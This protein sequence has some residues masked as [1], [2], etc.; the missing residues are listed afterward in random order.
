MQV[1]KEWRDK[2]IPLLDHPIIQFGSSKQ[3]KSTIR[4]LHYSTSNHISRRFRFKIACN[5]FK[6][7]F[8]NQKLFQQ[9]IQLCDL[10]FKD[11]NSSDNSD[12]DSID[13][14]KYYS[15]K[16]QEEKKTKEEDN[17]QP[18]DNSNIEFTNV[19]SLYLNSSSNISEILRF[20]SKRVIILPKLESI[21]FYAIDNVQLNQYLNDFD[22]YQLQQLIKLKTLV[23]INVNN[24]D[25]EILNYQFIHLKSLVFHNTN[26]DFNSISQYLKSTKTLENF[27]Y[28]NYNSSG[29]NELL[30]NSLAH[31]NSIQNLVLIS[32]MSVVLM[33]SIIEFLSVN[34]TVTDLKLEVDTRITG[35]EMRFMNTN[36]LSLTSNNSTE[37]LGYWDWNSTLIGINSPISL[38]PRLV[39]KL[40]S[41]HYQI[42]YLSI[43]PMTNQIIPH[44]LL[45]QLIAIEINSYAFENY[46]E[47]KQDRNT[48]RMW[49]EFFN[50]LKSVQL[51]REIKF[52]KLL[53]TDL[54]LDFFN[55]Q[56]PTI[57]VVSLDFYITEPLTSFEALQFKHFGNIISSNRTLKSLSLSFQE[58]SMEYGVVL[59]DLLISIIQSQNNIEYL[60]FRQSFSD[61]SLSHTKVLQ[62]CNAIT[63]NLKLQYYC[64][65]KY[66]DSYPLIEQTL[67][68]NFKTTN[69]SNS[70]FSF[71]K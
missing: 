69:T 20:L 27:E 57:E 15:F 59:G 13:K 52:Q 47:I 61:V 38:S 6:V 33:D 19:S 45:S 24:R 35:S 55:S 23:F 3:L 31:N 36:I 68:D 50:H 46:N 29:F 11:P 43:F 65:G 63:N 49:L 32:K 25:L 1:S 62:L 7:D 30:R 42:R 44:N 5:G 51:L 37:I 54:I 60:S 18:P 56:H 2:I 58:S 22:K 14:Y 40:V 8:D 10:K 34:Q 9:I 28:I 16:R 67:F 26:V 17:Y 21:Q 71:F 66:I 64:M 70:I 39:D 41:V 53:P 12:D 48:I 4:R